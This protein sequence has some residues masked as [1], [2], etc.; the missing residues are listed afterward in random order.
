MVAQ[1]AEI[2]RA[3]GAVAVQGAAEVVAELVVRRHLRAAWEVQPTDAR[4]EE[5]EE[6]LQS[7]AEAQLEWKAMVECPD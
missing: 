3:E 2:H 1:E 6:G 5:A 4:G 7:R